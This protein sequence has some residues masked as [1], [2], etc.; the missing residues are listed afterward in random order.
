MDLLFLDL[1]TW[2]KEKQNIKSIWWVDFFY[3]EKWKWFSFL[4]KKDD[5]KY[6]SF[7]EFIEDFNK[8]VYSYK[9][10]VGHNIIHHDFEHLAKE[11]KIDVNIFLNKRVIDTLYLQTLIFIEKP[12][13]HLVKDYKLVNKTNNPLENS[14]K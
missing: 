10:I 1:E 7:D 13:N 14:N 2:T 11:R 4:I 9:Y 3:N 6:H 8:I 12:Y 5:P